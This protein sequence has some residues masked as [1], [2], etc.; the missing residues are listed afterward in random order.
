MPTDDPASLSRQQ[1][2]DLTAYIFS[3]SGFPAGE[4]E[5][6]RDL[7]ALNQISIETRK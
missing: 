1:Y 6:P 4:R 7:P 3:V 5:L 2:A